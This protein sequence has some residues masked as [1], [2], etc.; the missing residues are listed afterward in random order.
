MYIKAQ[1]FYEIVK[2]LP[3]LKQKMT[4][5][6]SPHRSISHINH[7]ARIG[8]ASN[9]KKNFRNYSVVHDVEQL[10]SS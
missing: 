9:L 4:S 8:Q 7:I 3:F 6:I 1:I 10:L 2:R 5:G